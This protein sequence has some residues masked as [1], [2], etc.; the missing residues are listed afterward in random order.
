[1]TMYTLLCLGC[2]VVSS[3]THPPSSPMATLPTSKSLLDGI[4]IG[5]LTGHIRFEFKSY[6]F[7]STRAMMH[8]L[9][10]HLS[11]M[12]ASICPDS[13]AALWF[14]APSKGKVVLKNNSM[15][16][17]TGCK[18]V[19]S[20]QTIVKLVVDALRK[21][22]YAFKVLKIAINNMVGNLNLALTTSYFAEGDLLDIERISQDHCTFMHY[23]PE[24]FA[25]CTYRPNKSVLPEEFLSNKMTANLF[26]SG[27]IVMTGCRSFKAL[28]W[29]KTHIVNLMKKY[30]KRVPP[31]SNDSPKKL[32]P[33]PAK[34]KR[35]QTPQV[36]LF[37]AF[38]RNGA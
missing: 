7:T 17:I 13:K 23:E 33:I 9:K 21:S 5:M 35:V 6:P 12:K 18:S 22:G 14:H 32:Q 37:D 25:G 10:P 27:K 15:M 26:K 2:P 1:M 16:F 3:L 24:I 30:V 19:R 28:A 34:K 31:R 11:D 29:F 38:Y 20:F 36:T 8:L 4:S